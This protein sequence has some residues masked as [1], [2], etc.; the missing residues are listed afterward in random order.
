MS[1]Q[2]TAGAILT[3]TILSHH[4]LIIMNFIMATIAIALF[5]MIMKPT[6]RNIH[7]KKVTSLGGIQACM[8]LDLHGINKV[9][10]IAIV[11]KKIMEI[12]EHIEAVEIDQDTFIAELGGLEDD[13]DCLYDLCDLVI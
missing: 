5:M 6:I 10:G 7:H 12:V 9:H 13:L 3:T 2:N 8:M 11:V 1:T 4:T